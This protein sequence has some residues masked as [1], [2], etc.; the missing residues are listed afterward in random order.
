[1]MNLT[2]TYL[3]FTLPHPFVPGASPLGNDLDAVKRLEDAGA[4]MLTLPSLFEEEI[5]RESL[6]ASSA[7]DTPQG[8]FAEALSYLPDVVDYN[9]GPENY[10]EHLHLIK[11]TVSMPVVASL[12]GTTHGGWLDYA[13]LMQQAGAD[14]LELNI[15]EVATDVHRTSQDLERDMVAMVHEMSSQLIIPFAVKLSPFFTSIPNICR[16]F[17]DAGADGL[18]LFN[19][20]YQPDIDVEELALIRSLR[21]STSWELPLRLRWVAILFGNV[22][23]SLAVTGGVHSA[24][25][26][27]K[28]TMCGANVCQVVSA[29]LKHGPDHIRSLTRDLGNWLE[30]HE[31]ESLHQMRGSMSM[32]RSPDPHAFER[33]NYLH[34]LKSWENTL[35]TGW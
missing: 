6:A 8:Q 16:Q 19:R 20:F 18:V 26:A 9:V 28:A 4:P 35:M 2:T 17:D 11:Q 13:K 27:V 33:A 3:G 12:N 14:A 29:L 23:A 15:Y 10:L 34:I 25:D 1:M 7:I 21:L 31:Y 32:Q 30:A 5:R 24:I 22:Q